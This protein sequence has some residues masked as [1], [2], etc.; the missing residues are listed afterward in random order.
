MRNTGI[1]L[2]A[3][4][5]L[6]ELGDLEEVKEFLILSDLTVQPGDALAASVTRTGNAKCERCWRH[7]PS[8]GELEAAPDLCERCAEVM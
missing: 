5:L 4:H 1:S 8:V 7:E 2:G 6:D 3:Q